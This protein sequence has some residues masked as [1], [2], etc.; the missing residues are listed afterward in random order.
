[1]KNGGKIQRKQQNQSIR[2][3]R[4]NFRQP[5]ECIIGVPKE[6]KDEKGQKILEE[7]RAEI[8]KV[9][10]SCKSTDQRCSMNPK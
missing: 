2:E 8:S 9:D 4:V 3:L 10:E 5:K 1:M 7:I 6:S